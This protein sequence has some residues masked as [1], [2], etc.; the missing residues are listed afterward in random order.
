[1]VSPGG[2]ILYFHLYLW[3]CL[4]KTQADLLPVLFCYS[5]GQSTRLAWRKSY[6]RAG[7]SDAIFRRK[8]TIVVHTQQCYCTKLCTPENHTY[9]NNKSS[10]GFLT[11]DSSSG[12]IPACFQ[13]LEL[14][15]GEDKN[16]TGHNWMDEKTL[17]LARNRAPFLQLLAKHHL[18]LLNATTAWKIRFMIAA[19][20]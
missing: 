10:S 15:R 12:W 17:K 9:P 19:S 16:T 5:G 1:M 20:R 8:P 13:S 7:R 11:G 4:Q 6:Y 18:E 2:L 14:K 3:L